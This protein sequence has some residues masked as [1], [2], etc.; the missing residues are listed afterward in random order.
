MGNKN[1]NTIILNYLQ[2]KGFGVVSTEYYNF[3]ET[4]ENWWKNEVEFHKYRD[5]SGKE[6]KMYTLGM[7]KRLSEDWSSIVLSERDEVKTIANNNEQT[8]LN[9][10]YLEKDFNELELDKELQE[11]VEKASALGTVAAVW[12]INNVTVRGDTVVANK[13]T[14]KDI[15]FLTAR[16]IIPLKVEHGKIIDVAFISENTTNKKTEYY[17]EIHQKVWDKK[18]EIEKYVITNTYLDEQ[19]NEINKEGIV[20]SYTFNSDIPLFSIC[21]TPIANPLEVDYKTNGLGYSM[22]GNA[23]DQLI[24]CDIAYNNFVMDF[25]LGGKKVFYNKKIVKMETIQVKNSDGNIIEKQIPLYPDDLTRQQWA[26]YGDEMQQLNNEPAVKEYN[27]DLRVEEDTKGIQ[28]AL[29]VLS[30][31]SGL[32]MKYYQFNSNGVVTATQYTGDRQDLVK[33]AKKFRKNV[34]SFIK[35]ICK[36]SLF[37][38]R[39]IFNENVTE[40]CE[41]SLIDQDGFLVDTETAKAEFRQDIAQGIRQTWEYRVKFLGEDE[42][43]AKAIVYGDDIENIEDDEEDNKTNNKERTTNSSDKSNK[44]EKN[45]EEE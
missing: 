9:N 40:D 34:N 44:K 38:G 29:D 1:N 13:R 39:I 35:G 26:T 33:N 20:K 11:S 28:F 37:L 3:I 41:I 4:W 2:K 5:Q 22:F 45:E 43:T 14:K 7:A 32:G 18:L 30:F 12:R 31:K 6:R 42:E 25:Y 24:A 17:I 23:I 27:P 36:A 15:I 19:G 21:K 8:E 16:Q 10:K